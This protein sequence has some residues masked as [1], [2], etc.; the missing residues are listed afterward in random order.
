MKK[1]LK[2][3]VLATA[4]GGL[5]MANAIDGT[6]EH[7]GHQMQAEEVM[8]HAKVNNVNIAERTINVSHGPIKKLHWPAMTMDMKVADDVDIASL[9]SGQEVMMALARGDDGIF[10]ITKLMLH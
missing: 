5:N 2:L 7:K 9:D 8:V 4:F 3:A 10:R 1:I 6:H